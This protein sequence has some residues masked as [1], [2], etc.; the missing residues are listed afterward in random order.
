[1]SFNKEEIKK[2]YKDYNIKIEIIISFFII[3][4]ADIVC[5]FIMSEPDSIDF[6]S[7]VYPL[8]VFLGIC[9]VGA[10]IMLFYSLFKIPK[11]SIF[12]FVLGYGLNAI[13]ISIN[14][15][16]YNWGRAGFLILLFI[17]NAHFVGLNIIS[18]L[19]TTFKNNINKFIESNKKKIKI[20]VSLFLTGYAILILYVSIF[21]KKSAFS[22]SVLFLAGFVATL[23]GIVFNKFKLE[24]ANTLYNILIFLVAFSP[25]LIILLFS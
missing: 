4:I 6:S 13:M 21:V 19:N 8:I 2:H 5:V 18:A 25:S 11:Y 12:S 10:I 24:P 7:F 14:S 3:L 15:I 16:M 23:L 17:L 20:T 22:V 9:L 1:M